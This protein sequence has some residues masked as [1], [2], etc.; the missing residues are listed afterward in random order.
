ML[1]VIILTRDEERHIARAI[2]SVADIASKIFV[3][4]SGSTDRTVKIAESKGAHVLFNPWTNHA[5]QFNWALEQLARDTGWVLRLDADEVVSPRLAAEIASGLEGLSPDVAGVSVGRRMNFLGQPV[6][7][8]GVFPVRL[9][10]IFRHGHGKCEE[11]WM[12][13]HIVV[14]GD[15]AKFRG[16]IIDDNRNPLSWW[17]AKHND[18]ASR[19]V[20]ELLNL[21]Y[22]FMEP[23]AS[24]H[25]RFS[26]GAGWKRFLK[27]RCYAQLPIG[28]RAF[29]Y[30][31]YRYVVR[32]G[33]FDTREAAAFHVLQGFWYRYLVDIK[34]HEVK[35][36]MEEDGLGISEAIFEVLGV[37]LH[38]PLKRAVNP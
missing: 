31:L 21:E 16:D 20:I 6:R 17:T 33:F 24:E 18:Y 11:R 36:R 8:G 35:C 19:E 3:V 4:D 13:E 1:T 28:L 32:L 22:G 29:C 5:S 26:R 9:I 14:S 25:L 2:D 23:S 12:D 34:L 15:V 37:E 38:L 27:E 30:F 10:R 7:R